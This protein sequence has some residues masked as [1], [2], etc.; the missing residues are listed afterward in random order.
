[1]V[2]TEL[3][4]AGC[5]ICQIVFCFGRKGQYSIL[6]PGIEN[7]AQKLG[8]F[9]LAACRNYNLRRHPVA[10]SLLYNFC[11]FYFTIP[12]IFEKHWD[13]EWDLKESPLFFHGN[14]KQTSKNNFP[15]YLYPK[16]NE[17]Y[18]LHIKIDELL[19]DATVFLG[20]WD[21]AIRASARN[22]NFSCNQQA[23]ARPAVTASS[24]IAAQSP[25]K[26]NGNIYLLV[27]PEICYL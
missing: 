15:Y 25:Y 19:A 18:H 27:I 5:F 16:S 21:G 10:I 26:L 6:G 9:K 7:Y 22:C 17:I 12:M 20:K 4:I 1:M 11:R 3:F 13:I 24:I 8:I 2:R 14:Y 23:I